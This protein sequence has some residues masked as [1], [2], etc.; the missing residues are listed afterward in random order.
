MHS[1]GFADD[2]AICNELP[3]S[4]AGVGIRDFA[5]FIRIQPDLALS[6]SNDRGR[7]ALLS[8]E[9]DPIMK[10]VVSLCWRQNEKR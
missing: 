10:T 5:D 3:D 1:D 7:Q 6:A 2:E 8:S 9:I 4:L